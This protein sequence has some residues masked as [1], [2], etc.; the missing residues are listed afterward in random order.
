MLIILVKSC[1]KKIQKKNLMILIN[2]QLKVIYFIKYLFIICLEQDM[3][4]N[5]KNVIDQ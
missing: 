5:Y 2:L 1:K 4:D 3:S